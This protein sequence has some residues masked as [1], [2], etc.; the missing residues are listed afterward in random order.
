LKRKLTS[1]VFAAATLAVAA[2]ATHAKT[3]APGEYRA[4]LQKWINSYRADHGLR[5]LRA[6]P[7]VSRSA[8][9][10]STDMRRGRFFSHTS[11]NG[12]TWSSRIRYYG[13]RQPVIGENIAVGRLRPRDTFRA[14]RAS[15]S[16][17]ALMLDPRFKGIG[18]SM[19]VGVYNGARAYYVTADFSGR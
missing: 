19:R 7:R 6:G 1:M 15:P 2:P 14:W 18:I 3:Y 16:H 17:R 5:R 10:H 11:S 9:A 4:K 8:L 13:C 12:R